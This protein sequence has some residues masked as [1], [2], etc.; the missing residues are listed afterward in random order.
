MFDV[1]HPTQGIISE[2]RSKLEL[3]DLFIFLYLLVFIRQYMW[4]VPANPLAWA[5][6]LTLAAVVWTMH[7]RIKGV[8][9]EKTPRMF[10]LIV[11]LPLLLIFALKFALPDISFDVLNH[12]LIQSEKRF[13]RPAFPAR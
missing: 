12:R 8:V 13:A 9:E 2:L 11:A 7:L 1:M 10:W 6:T 5:L 4:L 3:G